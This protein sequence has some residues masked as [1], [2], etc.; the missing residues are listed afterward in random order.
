MKKALALALVVIFALGLA[1]FAETVRVGDLVLHD[2]Y[3]WYT[4]TPDIS[5]TSSPCQIGFETPFPVEIK[6][7]ACGDQGWLYAFVERNQLIYVARVLRNGF[8][9]IILP[10]LYNEGRWKPGWN[11]LTI[12]LSSSPRFN[13]GDGHRPQTITSRNF[14]GYPCLGYIVVRQ[15]SFYVP[16][17]PCLPCCWWCCSGKG[18]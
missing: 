7:L 2:Y 17:S 14:L 15:I 4:T 5:F 1:A 13:I 18:P 6:N 8:Q 10:S 11:T 3:L 9:P 12:V 16:Y